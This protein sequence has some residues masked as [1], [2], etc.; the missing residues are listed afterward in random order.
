MTGVSVVWSMVFSPNLN[1]LLQESLRDPSKVHYYFCHRPTSLKSTTP[2][3]YADDTQIT[4]TA[5]T[6]D[7]DTRIVG[8]GVR[9]TAGRPRLH[10][11]KRSWL[12]LK[13]WI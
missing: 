7:D 4:A 13:K 8:S 1:I 6:V 5:E 12:G 3:M 10:F 2:G 9:L 11:R